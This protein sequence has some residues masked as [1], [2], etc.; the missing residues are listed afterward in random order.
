[1]SRLAVTLLS[2]PRRR[3]RAARVAVLLAVV[4]AGAVGIVLL[5][6]LD[7]G[8]RGYVKDVWEPGKPVVVGN[9]K[10]VRLTPSARRE[11]N[12]TLVRF[13]RAGVAKKDL[14]SVYKLVTPEFRGGTT[15]AQWRHG[16]SPIYAYPAPTGPVANAWRLNYSYRGDVGVALMLSS[17]LR[18]TVGSVIFHIEL[19]ERRGR[20]LVDSFSPVAT[21]TPIGEGPQHETGPADYAGSAAGGNSAHAEKAPLSPLWIIVPVIAVGLSLLVPLCLFV[22]GRVRERRAVRAYESTLPKRLPPLPRRS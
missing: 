22:I 16:N 3:R 5:T 14:A 13:V 17:R 4:G 8:N 6:R 10:P 9:E 1:M 2:S 11:I 15:L 21:F 20:W 18:K 19:K 12:A 7:G